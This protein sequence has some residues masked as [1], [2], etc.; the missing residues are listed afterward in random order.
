MLA[1][2]RAFLLHVVVR[3][4]EPGSHAYWRINIALFLAGFATFSLLYCV[5]PLL[6]LFADTFQVSPAGSSLAL[7]LSTAC[8]ALSILVSGALSEGQDQRRF[9]FVSMLLAAGCNLL[10]AW[11]PSWSSLL[12]ARAL[13]GLA[14]GGVPALAMAYLAEHMAGKGL[15][16]AVGLYVGGTA[17]GGM[18]GRVGT[19][20][21]AEWVSWREALAVLSGLDL[22]VAF[23]FVCLLPRD[24]RRPR[25]FSLHWP[26]HWQAWRRHLH[27]PTLPW[28]F[29]TGGLVM[30][31]FVTVF[32]YVS[33]RL[34]RAPFFLSAAHIGLIFCAYVFGMVASPAAG[35]WA[36]RIGRRPVMVAGLLV[37]T[38]GVLLTLAPSLVLVILGIVLVTI[39]FFVAHAVASSWVGRRASSH[40]GHAASLYLLAYYLGSS[41][42]GSCGG[43]FWSHGG[44]PA[45]VGMTVTL[46]VLQLGLTRR[47][48][49][50]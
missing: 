11:L 32:N 9:M 4:H 3:M 12:L 49:A 36:D 31:V 30:G 24:E 18:A 20:V 35:A 28:L 42:L 43:W 16:L 1:I 39:G 29:V 50:E 6:P 22:L 26:S 13:V 47:L 21:L 23:G 44:W 34:M 41:V 2:L 7:S 8:L 45:V 19:S 46:L 40:K 25:P 37:M 5:Q 10:A 14:L 48:P 33:F 17:F 38:L 15:S 27:H